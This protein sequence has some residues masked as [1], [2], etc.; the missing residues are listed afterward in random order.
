M[1]LNM[2]FEEVLAEFKKASEPTERITVIENDTMPVRT[3]DISV[4]RI[5]KACNSSLEVIFDKD[6][7]EVFFRFYSDACMRFIRG[8]KTKKELACLFRCLTVLGDGRYADSNKI[9]EDQEN[10]ASQE[11]PY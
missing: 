4:S 11:I 9:Q 2:T 3:S 6:T 5:S 8:P 7:E 10:V 1:G